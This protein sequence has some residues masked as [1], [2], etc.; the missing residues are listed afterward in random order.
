MAAL[1][2]LVCVQA[3]NVVLLDLDMSPPPVASSKRSAAPEP[4]QTRS[5]DSSPTKDRSV[6][7]SQSW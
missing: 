5:V 3:E 6:R 2:S 4:N 1:T 7:K